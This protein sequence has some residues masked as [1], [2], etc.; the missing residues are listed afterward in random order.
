M[1]TLHRDYDD[2]F[3]KVTEQNIQL[4]KAGNQHASS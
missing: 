4:R 3:E 1:H 2:R